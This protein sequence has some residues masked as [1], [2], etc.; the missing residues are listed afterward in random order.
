MNSVCFQKK[1]EGN[2][3]SSV[4]VSS[5]FSFTASSTHG[6]NSAKF[7]LTKLL[8]NCRVTCHGV[9][10]VDAFT[11]FDLKFDAKQHYIQL[12]DGCRSNELATV[13]G[14]AEFR[15]LDAN[16][17]P[18]KVWLTNA[19]LA[20]ELPVKLFPVC[21]ATDSGAKMT[22]AKYTACLTT[23]NTAFNICRQGQLYFLPTCE[24]D[25]TL[26]VQSLNQW[27]ETLGHVNYD[28]ILQLQKVTRRMTVINSTT[29]NTMQYLQRLAIQSQD[30]QN[31]VTIRLFVQA[32]LLN[33]HTQTYATRWNQ[34]RVRATNMLSILLTISPACSS[35]ILCAPKTKLQLL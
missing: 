22:F 4:S 6:A 31:L 14:I 16:N 26:T 35:C 29:D 13:R 12:A 8:V 27:H 3:Q 34:H 24:T 33:V 23:Q 30:R 9:N 28:D 17:A 7:D 5:S 15:I 1:K 21:A 32:N 25:S 19:L 10:N 18:Q 11:S 2:T 20:P